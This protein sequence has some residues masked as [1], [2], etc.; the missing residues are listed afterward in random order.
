MQ[1]EKITVSKRLLA[2]FVL[3]FSIFSIAFISIE[4]NHQCDDE[5]CQIC[6]VLN[7][8]EGNLKLLSL[9]AAF[10]FIHKSAFN[11]TKIFS[12][13]QICFTFNTDTLI[14]RKIRMNN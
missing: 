13:K 6:Y 14:S 10:L 5:S 12:F 4:S 8:A 2:I 7:V 9:S 1:N 11:V 3:A